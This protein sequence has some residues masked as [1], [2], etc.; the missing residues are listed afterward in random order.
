MNT[1]FLGLGNLQSNKLSTSLYKKTTFT[2][3]GTIVSIATHLANLRSTQPRPSYIGPINF[4]SSSF[5]AFDQEINFLGNFFTSNGYPA[6]L[7]DAVC[8]KIL[9]KLTHRASCYRIKNFLTWP[10]V[11]PVIVPK[12]QVY[13]SVSYYITM[14]ASSSFKT[15]PIDFRSS[16][17]KFSSTKTFLQ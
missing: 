17:L 8:E 10:T 6:F 16:T 9:D 15:S 11:P 7:F 2:G 1:T 12:M 3:L 5:C 4:L 14:G 13:L